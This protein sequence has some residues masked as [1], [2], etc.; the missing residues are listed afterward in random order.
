MGGYVSIPYVSR[1]VIH[2]EQGKP[3]TIDAVP[4]DE[5]VVT[6]T[7]KDL[8][9]PAPLPPIDEEKEKEKEDIK[10]VEEVKEIVNDVKVIAEDVKEVVKDVKEIVD[11]PPQVAKLSIQIPEDEEKPVITPEEPEARAPEFRGNMNSESHAVKKFNRRHRKH[12][13]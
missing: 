1:K 12:N 2:I 3:A 6:L 9:P 4:S 7:E 13:K 8:K 5:E 11:F 10:I